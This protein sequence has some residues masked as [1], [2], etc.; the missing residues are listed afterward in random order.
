MAVLQR[1]KSDPPHL[2]V[3]C[4]RS[5]NNTPGSRHVDHSDDKNSG[6]RNT[7]LFISRLFAFS[8]RF[9]NALESFQLCKLSH[10][11][12]RISS[13]MTYASLQSFIFSSWHTIQHSRLGW[14]EYL[15]FYLWHFSTV[16]VAVDLVQT[17]AFGIERESRR[18]IPL[19]IMINCGGVRV[20]NWKRMWGD[21]CLLA[22]LLSLYILG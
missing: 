2:L 17:T 10:M 11:S 1:T 5:S 14:R 9:A 16:R 12:C 7:R 13:N 19:E 8:S 20:A 6:I 15:E 4:S 3:N 21:D 22:S 18:R